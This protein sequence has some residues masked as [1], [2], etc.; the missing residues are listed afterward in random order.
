MS[1]GEPMVDV[2][3]PCFR[4]AVFLAEAIESVL[5]QTFSRWRLTVVDNGG[6]AEIA[7]VVEPYLHDGRITYLP[8]IDEVP[9]AVNWTRAVQHGDAP[10]VALLND[11]DT[12]LPEFLEKRVGA[13][14]K[15]PECGF[16]FGAC[17]YLDAEGPRES[18]PW[19]PEGV[20]PRVELARTFTERNP[21]VPSAVVVRRGTLEQ[22]GA[23]FDGRWHYC[24][25]EM[26]GRLGATAPAYFVARPDSVFRRHA[27]TNTF[28]GHE[29]PAQLMAMVDHL[30]RM[31]HVAVPRFRR[32][33]RNR[34]R[35]RAMILLRAAADVHPG[36]G[37]KVSRQLYTSAIRTYPP[38]LFQRASVAMLAKSVLG[39]RASR[40]SADALRAI[41]RAGQSKTRKAR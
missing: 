8:S 27:A 11:D 9:L 13:L 16:A 41:G 32:S 23:A 39:K 18:E 14:H 37:W 24:D 30:E 2:G 25:W 17:Y 6:S 12:W 21:V 31:F 4:R 20:V 35:S 38:V 28:A 26:W 22:A 1:G 15:H 3:L 36:G 19:F 7:A 34:R 33:R 29:T 5:A 40:A 10:Y